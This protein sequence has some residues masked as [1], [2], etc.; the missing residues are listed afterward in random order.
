MAALWNYP[1]VSLSPSVAEYNTIRE[2]V[3]SKMSKTKASKFFRDDG[4]CRDHDEYDCEECMGKVNKSIAMI[5]IQGGAI[6]GGNE[7]DR[8]KAIENFD[9]QIN[10]IRTVSSLDEEALNKIKVKDLPKAL[11]KAQEDVTVGHMKKLLSNDRPG[12]IGRF[13]QG[14]FCRLP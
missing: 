12:F 9:R 7:C 14:V 10:F 3:K 2:G 13:V 6:G 8:A 11:A 1:S 5:P 4:S